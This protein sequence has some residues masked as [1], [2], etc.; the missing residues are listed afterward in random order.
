M[1]WG[2][3]AGRRGLLNKEGEIGSYLLPIQ[4]RSWFV[5]ASVQTIGARRRASGMSRNI[6]TPEWAMLGR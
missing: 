6:L 5:N 4:L 2:G 3:V 1:Q